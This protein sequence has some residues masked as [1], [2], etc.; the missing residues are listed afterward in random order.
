MRKRVYI[1]GPIS[2]GDM[3]HNVQQADDAFF[4]LLRGGFAPFNPM[5]SV[6]S[7]SA[8]RDPF[9]D[10]LATAGSLPRGTT[11]ADWL[12][13]DLPWVAVAD[14]VLR[15]PGE[16]VGADRETDMAHIH[17][18]P[19]FHSV[20]EVKEYFAHDRTNQTPRGI[21]VEDLPVEAR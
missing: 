6:F 3:L 4:D 15:L 9:D 20:E 12:D 10:V 17:G 8:W 16:S 1:A 19:V 21:M 14:A 7:G 18:V 2:K 11:H 13:A 5:L